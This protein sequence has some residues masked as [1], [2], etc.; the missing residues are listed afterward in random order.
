MREILLG[1]SGS[2]ACFKAAGLASQLVQLGHGVTALLSP[3]A[4]RFVTPLQ[5]SCL[6]G[7]Q[8]LS[9]E[10][11]A[12]DPAGMDHIQLARRADLLIVVPATADRIGSLAHGL[13]SDLLGSTALAFEAHKPRLYAPAM[14]PAMWA[15]PAVQRNV[16]LL[17]SDGWQ[18]VGPVDGRTACVE[19]GP[20]RLVEI[21]DIL[22]A[23][24]QSLGN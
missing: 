5:F 13:A 3:A 18:R 17:E 11:M 21:E 20:G 2:A 24:G 10:W 8:A 22:Q 7:R 4:T 1:V 12:Q 15:N 16:G 19:S 14:N 9:D 6:T 23:I